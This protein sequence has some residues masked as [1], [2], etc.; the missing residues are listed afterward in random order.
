SLA[1]RL[2][3][4]FAA[5][6]VVVTAV[7]SISPYVLVKDTLE[8]QMEDRGGERLKRMA[9]PITSHL[10]W[11][12]NASIQVYA[13]DVTKEYP[14]VSY[15][16]VANEKGVFLGHSEKSFEGKSWEGPGMQGKDGTTVKA[17]RHRGERML[18]MALPVDVDGKHLGTIV[19]GQNYREVNVVLSRL[20]LRLGGVGL[21]ILIVSLLSTRPFTTH[22]VSGL[23]RLGKM[24]REV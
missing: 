22:V 10:A 21:F 16:A 1:V 12:D 8:S 14:E 7:F 18:E 11:G 3:L 19:I 9:H 20:L 2:M 6:V 15:A 5:F 4:S 17:A 13:G 23:T 24:T